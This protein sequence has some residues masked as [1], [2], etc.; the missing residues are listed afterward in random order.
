MCLVTSYTTHRQIWSSTHTGL[1]QHCDCSPTVQVFAVAG[2]VGVFVLWHMTRRRR[3][4][5]GHV[6]ARDTLRSVPEALSDLRNLL[7]PRNNRAVRES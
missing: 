7:R 4:S 1:F 3:P 2:V 6:D 5:T